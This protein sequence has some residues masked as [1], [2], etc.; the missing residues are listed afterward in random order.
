MSPATPA[1]TE[2]VARHQ[3]Q[4]R[5]LCSAILRDEHL[6]ADA[7]QETFLRLW[8]ALSTPAQPAHWGRWLRRVAVRVALDLTRRRQRSQRRESTV[9]VA[10]TQAAPE[11]WQGAARGELARDLRSALEHL[12]P[13]QQIVFQ[14][15]Q[16]GGLRLAEIAEALERSLPTVKT[17][18][19]RACWKLQ[20]LL[21]PHRDEDHPS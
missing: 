1:F 18:F 19:A 15:R 2:L 4:V 9:A 11:P 21:A 8:K 6:S 17:Q 14:L 20:E 3:G 7:T 13:Q 12:S 10:E 16:E 5:R